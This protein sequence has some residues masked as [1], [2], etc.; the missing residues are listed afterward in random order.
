MVFPAH[1]G[2]LFGFQYILLGVNLLFNFQGGQNYDPKIKISECR[3]KYIK[4]MYNYP[5]IYHALS[6]WN[7]ACFP[8]QNL[9]LIHPSLHHPKVPYKDSIT[10]MT[11]QNTSL[12]VFQVLPTGVNHLGC[13]NS[14]WDQLHI[15][16][17]PHPILIYDV[18]RCETSL[19]CI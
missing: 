11:K 8:Q 2:F 16:S 18:V 4:I 13:E 10:F 15:T 17:K 3:S 9:A 7:G 19:K 6:I 14:L 12:G 5:V 1:S